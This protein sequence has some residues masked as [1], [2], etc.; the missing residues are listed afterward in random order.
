MMILMIIPTSCQKQIDELN[1]QLE[2]QAVLIEAQA[3]QIEAL[4]N[5]LTITVQALENAIHN[6]SLDIIELN[7]AVAANSQAIVD[8]Y[9]SLVEADAELENNIAQ[10]QIEVLQALSNEVSLLQTN[11]NTLDSLQ[12]QIQ[13]EIASLENDI[14]VNNALI[15][16]SVEQLN[17]AI[18]SIDIP[19]TPQTQTIC[20]LEAEEVPAYGLTHRSTA[21]FTFPAWPHIIHLDVF[22]FNNTDGTQPL[23]R[24]WDSDANRWLGDL[25]EVEDI[26]APQF[27]NTVGAFSHISTDTNMIPIA[28]LPNKHLLGKI[29][30]VQDAEDNAPDVEL[31]YIFDNGIYEG[32]VDGD[33]VK[34]Y[35]NGEKV[36]SGNIL[37]KQIADSD[38][39]YIVT[40]E[41]TIDGEVYYAQH[42]VEASSS[43]KATNRRGRI[44]VRRPTI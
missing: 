38:G 9:N 16:S 22:I 26:P 29:V 7:N 18:N 32:C 1:E 37:Y 19:G 11:I 34:W 14:D 4:Q 28:D 33:D 25:I 21:V 44:K 43:G 42:L 13:T 39:F 24:V 41:T 5:T 2:E 36:G 35:V 40:A 20:D 23:Y 10:S 17:D 3:Q 12:V 6:N 31:K 30:A 27:G 8:N 15:R